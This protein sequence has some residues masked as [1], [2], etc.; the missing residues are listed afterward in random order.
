M[1]ERAGPEYQ[2]T[3]KSECGR[4][5]KLLTVLV[6]DPVQKEHRFYRPARS[7]ACQR[8]PIRCSKPTML[9]GIESP[10]R[11]PR[12]RLSSTHGCNILPTDLLLTAL[13]D[14]GHAGE[15]DVFVECSK[16]WQP[17]CCVTIQP[18]RQGQMEK[19]EV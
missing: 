17:S 12:R 11:G 13:V 3:C 14:E 18:K 4:R 8:R 7:S 5:A 15:C 1:S 9:R 10:G 16:L 6:C 2:L 19:R